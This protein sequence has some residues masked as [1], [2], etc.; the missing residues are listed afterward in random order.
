MKKYRICFL[1]V[2]LT[3]I[4]G[5]FCGCVNNNIKAI[6]NA[7]VPVANLSIVSFDGSGESQLGLPNLGHSFI[8]IKNTSS[9]EL[10][11]GNYP[12]APNEEV[13]IGTWSIKEHFGVWYNVESNYIN[14][15]NKYDGRVSVT[16]QISLEELNSI[17]NFIANHNKWS[18]L[19]NCSYFAINLWNSIAQE[20]EKL[21][22]YLIYK[23]AKLVN[24]LKQFNEFNINQIFNTSTDVGYFLESGYKTFT[25]GGKQ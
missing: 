21:S 13:C 16:Q 15:N 23:P 2:L 17:S 25:F 8:V 9:Q 1:V 4:C 6:C 3:F 12:L 22:T 14:Y 24:E 10:I 5:C 11:A 18:A 19:K 7:L 20:S